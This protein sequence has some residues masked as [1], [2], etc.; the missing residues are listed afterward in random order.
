MSKRTA[1][2]MA[3]L[4]GVQSVAVLAS[5]QVTGDASAIEPV[6]SVQTWIK[7]VVTLESQ[8]Q[9][10]DAIATFR[11]QGLST[12]LVIRQLIYFQ[13]HARKLYTAE[14]L[15]DEELSKRTM[16]ANG[17]IALLL[18]WDPRSQQLTSASSLTLV[19]AVLPY[20]RTLDQPVKNELHHTLEW[21]DQLQGTKKDFT[22]YEVFLTASTNAPAD[23]LIGYMYDRDPSAAVRS[24]ARV[25]GSGSDEADVATAIKGDPKVA[26]QSLAARPEWWA[27]LYVAETMKK[28][29]R[30][31]DA[32]ILAQLERDEHPLVR[33]A[34]NATRTGQGYPQ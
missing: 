34:V 16:V 4:I 32:A 25:Y 19:K 28:T 23:A 13:A 12:E 17:V 3:V 26:L 8:Q 1:G 15:T 10:R 24:M 2:I 30:L 29:P 6:P 33:E 31:R 27:R 20:L 9:L 5:A 7:Q 11:K 14:T 21:V 18:D 22:Q